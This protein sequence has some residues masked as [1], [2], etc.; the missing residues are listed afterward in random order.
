MKKIYSVFVVLLIV[1]LCSCSQSDY[2]DIKITGE[3]INSSFSDE[4]FSEDD[5]VL[6]K[7]DGENVIYWFPKDYENICAAFYL[8]NETDIIK[9][10]ALTIANCKKDNCKDFIE[11]F[12]DAIKMNNK[13][14]ESENYQNGDLYT[15]L[16]FDKRYKQT[17]SSPTLKRKITDDD[18]FFPVLSDEEKSNQEQR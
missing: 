6:L 5:T 3:K 12:S 16:F 8:E 17:V 9:N 18:I 1:F 15:I 14:I 13:Y 11:K 7:E 2:T 10:C 4:I